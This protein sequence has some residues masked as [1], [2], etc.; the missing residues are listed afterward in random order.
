M[1][2]QDQQFFDEA[3]KRKYAIMQQNANTQAQEVAQKPEMQTAAEAA[4]A[5]RAQI[6]AQ[7]R[8]SAERLRGGFGLQERALANQGNL[9]VEQARGGFGLQERTLANQGNLAV[10]Q[11]RGNFGLQEWGMRADAAKQPDY[12]PMANPEYGE[13][14]QPLYVLAPRNQAA[15]EYLNA[16]KRPPA[17]PGDVK[18]PD[19]AS[20][21]ANPGLGLPKA[22][23]A[24][25]SPSVPQGPAPASPAAD[26]LANFNY[27]DGVGGGLPDSG[28]RFQFTSPAEALREARRRKA[29]Q[30]W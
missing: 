3:L 7:A 19:G 13:K 18:V 14:G 24:L 22:N 6:D 21:Q 4:A 30:S 25:P 17:V 12:L 15:L 8:L 2:Y 20:A 16:Q 9:A 11:A 1:A 28:S 23:A 10:E 26:K 27:A 29:E 5:N